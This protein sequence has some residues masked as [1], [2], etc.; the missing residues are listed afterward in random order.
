MAANGYMPVLAGH[1]DLH[2]FGDE[3]SHET[4]QL[5][6][7]TGKTDHLQLAALA[8]ESAFFVSDDAE[9]MHLA[10]SVGCQGV[11]IAHAK[12]PPAKPDG[13]HVVTLTASGNLG[14]ISPE[15]VWRTLA[16]MGLTDGGADAQRAAAAR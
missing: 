11:L 3:I 16:N 4:P 10:V 14:S 8:L 12:T 6:D 9:E 15:F 5:V 1:K 2:G 13:R 7:L